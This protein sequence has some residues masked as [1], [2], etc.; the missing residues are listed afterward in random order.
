MLQNM[1][2]RTA[3]AAA[4]A[5]ILAAAVSVSTASWNIVFGKVAGGNPSNNW[6]VVVVTTDPRANFFY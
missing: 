6:E 1:K 4:T 2:P 5:L 3:T